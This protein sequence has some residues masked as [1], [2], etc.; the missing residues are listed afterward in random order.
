MAQFSS[1]DGL[2]LTCQTCVIEQN[3]YVVMES[4]K[5][6]KREEKGYRECLRCGN[7]FSSVSPENRICTFCT[8]MNEGV[9]APN[10]N[11][12]T[13]A[14]PLSSNTSSYR[15]AARRC[16]PLSKGHG[17]CRVIYQRKKENEGSGS[18]GSS[19]EDTEN[20]SAG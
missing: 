9:E 17:E 20:R 4:S 18:S 19:G 12:S 7:S 11:S 13:F 5:L 6:K 1:A 14:H 10:V 16:D 2:E 8:R 3:K 15:V